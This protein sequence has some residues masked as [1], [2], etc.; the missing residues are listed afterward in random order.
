MNV[1]YITNK[2][3]IPFLGVVVVINE[4]SL[5]RNNKMGIVK[6]LICDS[7]IQVIEANSSHGFA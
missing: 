2:K 7:F 1:G 6:E 5:K 3:V 4:K